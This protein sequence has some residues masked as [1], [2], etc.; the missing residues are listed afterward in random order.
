MISFNAFFGSNSLINLIKSM[1]SFTFSLEKVLSLD[2]IVRNEEEKG[3][4]P[5]HISIVHVQ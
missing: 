4:V 1:R 3:S 2:L 5:H